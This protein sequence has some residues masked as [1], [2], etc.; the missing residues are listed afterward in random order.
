M[1]WPTVVYIDDI[2]ITGTT[3]KEHL[4]ALN[5]VLTRLKKITCSECVI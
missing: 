5:E 3:D 1:G 2:L 4:Q